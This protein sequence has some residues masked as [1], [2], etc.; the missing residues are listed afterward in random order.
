[1]DDLVNL[2]NAISPLVWKTSMTTAPK[3]I[4]PEA[5]RTETPH[6]FAAVVVYYHPDNQALVSTEELARFM[7]VVVVD[8]SEPAV[9]PKWQSDSVA[10]IPNHAN[11]G[12]AQALNA[13]ID[14]WQ[15]QGVT[16]CFLF[17][18]DSRIDHTFIQSMLTATK[19]QSHA[20]TAA[21][22][23]IY[24]AQNLGKYGDLIRLSKWRLERTSPH[25]L[26]KKQLHPV[27]YAISSGS[28][29]NLAVY[30]E[31]GPH[32]ESLFIDFVD[33]EWGLRASQLGYQVLTNLSAQLRH[34]LGDKP[35]NFLGKQIV[36]HSPLRHYYYCRNLMAMLRKG[37]VP[38]IWKLHELAKLPI[39]VALYSLCNRN[40]KAHFILM[41]SG[42]WDGLKHQK[43]KKQ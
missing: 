1:M 37:H 5:I 19:Q 2:A 27:T 36:N 11:L 17:D 43:G 13:G 38:A 25:K 30:P 20:K 15:Q 9:E 4:S 26:N 22:V 33:I 28:L 29:V 23:P 21:I 40:G 6:N 31:I 7:P 42:L 34:H 3:R 12:I 41:L 18:Q 14:Y 32:D 24:Y 35:V 8:N 10:Y 39:R 16:W